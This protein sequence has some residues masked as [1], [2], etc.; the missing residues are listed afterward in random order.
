MNV[1]WIWLSRLKFVGTV[2]QK[3]LVLQFGSPEAIYH[4][5]PSDLMST[6]RLS[7]RAIDSILNNKD[8]VKAMEIHTH[9]KKHGIQLLSYSDNLYPEY[10]RNYPESPILFYYIGHLDYFTEAVGVVGSRRCTVYGRKIAEEIGRELA[11]SK[12]TLISG[13]AK[14]IDSYAQ[15]SCLL[16]RG[17]TVIFLANG[18]D[19]CYPS[20]QRNLYQQT[21]E[22]G[23]VFL[24]PY[25]P[26]TKPYPQQF[27][28]RNSF[29][30]AWSHKLVVV[31]AGEKS[32]ALLTADFAF[33]QGKPVFSVPHPIDSP[34]GKGSNLLLAKG[35]M[36]YLGMASIFPSQ[37][38]EGTICDVQEKMDPILK[39][40]SKSK[41]SI[42]SIAV[43]LNTGEQTIMDRLLSLELEGKVIIR[44]NIAS[45]L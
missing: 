16:H 11:L 20:E 3:R 45:L 41:K 37:K 34:D 32:G 26:G 31:E 13:F 15:A 9:C 18:V 24:S 1:Y 12:K 14:G 36:P 30:S 5:T 38:R 33:K 17:Y 27:V 42:S 43:A 23:G 21:L 2:F 29:I 4:A 40:L 44:G 25:P 8:L 19:I 35:G 10:A 28:I 22:S 6:P 7:K 39:M